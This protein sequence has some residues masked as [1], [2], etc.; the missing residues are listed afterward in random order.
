MVQKARAYMLT[1]NNPPCN[2]LAKHDTERYAC[3]QL[4]QGT[5]CETP[6]IQAYLYFKNAIS[7][8]TVKKLYPKAHI[9]IAKGNVTQCVDYCSKT[10]TRKEGPWTRGTIPQQGQRNDIEEAIAVIAED[11]GKRK[12]FQRVCE[13]HPEVVV[14]YFKGLM[15][16]ANQ[17]IRPRTELPE[18]IVYYGTTGCGK[19][20]AAREWL[21]HAWI[22]NPAK[23]PWFDGYLGQEEAIFEE[24]RG[25]LPYAM[26]LSILDRYTHEHQVKGGMVDFV[27]KRIAITSPMPP[28]QWYPR[29]CEKVDSIEQLLRRITKVVNLSPEAE[30][31]DSSSDNDE[32]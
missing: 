5:Q 8:N 26:L 14:K 12:P 3:W 32:S 19:S 30:H 29:Q 11:L 2:E 24:Y 21:P 17:L 27:A 28:E 1:I 10:D 15:F 16:V 25:Q 20:R 22:W 13:D 6:H 23:G 18:V 7:F 9:E 31:N 4:E